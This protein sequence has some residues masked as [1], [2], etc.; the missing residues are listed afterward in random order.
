[1]W[2]ERLCGILMW[3]NI[4]AWFLHKEEEYGK[5]IASNPLIL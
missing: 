3:Q 4:D 1:M 5:N 2:Y